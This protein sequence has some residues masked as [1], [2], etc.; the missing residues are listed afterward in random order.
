LDIQTDLKRNKSD[1]ID[2]TLAHPYYAI[3]KFLGRT[4]AR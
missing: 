2:P 4:L 1:F 3:K